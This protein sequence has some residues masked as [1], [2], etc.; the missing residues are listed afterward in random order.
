MYVYWYFLHLHFT[1]LNLHTPLYFVQQLLQQ[2]LTWDNNDMASYHRCTDLHPVTES[3][4][5]DK[6]LEEE[7]LSIC[8]KI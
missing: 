6:D 5:S 4:L 8:I 2:S 3:L 1:W 7:I